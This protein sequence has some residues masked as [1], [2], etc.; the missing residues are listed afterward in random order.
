MA[1]GFSLWAA[2]SPAPC[3]APLSP[4]N[5]LSM[6]TIFYFVPCPIVYVWG[7]VYR[8]YVCMCA[9]VHVDTDM[10]ACGECCIHVCVC[11]HV[12]THPHVCMWRPEVDTR[13]LPWLLSVDLGF[14]IIKQYVVFIINFYKYKWFPYGRFSVVERQVQ[15]S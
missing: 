7:H 11:V 12:S 15:M 8:V 5:T 13:C 2:L 4:K 14:V 6:L 3:Q 9:Y 1:P 10:C